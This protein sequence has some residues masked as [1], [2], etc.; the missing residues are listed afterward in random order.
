M[1][2]DSVLTPAF[3]IAFANLC[4]SLLGF[5]TPRERKA[6]VQV[7]LDD[8]T[9]RLSYY[10]V[11]TWYYAL[12]RRRLRVTL[13][14]TALVVGYVITYL[15]TRFGFGQLVKT[16]WYLMLG[17]GLVFLVG[18]EFGISWLTRAEPDV[19]LKRAGFVLGSIVVIAVL[20]V[21]ASDLISDSVVFPAIIVFSVF[22]GILMWSALY[23]IL[24]SAAR[25][26]VKLASFLMWGIVAS[27][28]GAL[29]ALLAL[30]TAFL[31]FLKALI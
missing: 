2:L 6:K 18:M 30:T 19:G 28:E 26:L 21:V 29:P 16:R 5:F 8:W 25:L 12:R 15:A 1:E 3:W 20:I 14:L 7:V 10:D 11:K 23:V 27:K 31:A 9:L 24:S 4:V 22:A 13:S 17:H